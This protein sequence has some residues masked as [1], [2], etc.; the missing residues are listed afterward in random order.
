MP[1]RRALTGTGMG[2][3]D[4]EPRRREWHRGSNHESSTTRQQPPCNRAGVE[5]PPITT[6][7]VPVTGA[8]SRMKNN[9]TTFPSV[10]QDI[11]SPIPSE[12]PPATTPPSAPTTT[13]APNSAHPRDLPWDRRHRRTSRRS[14]SRSRCGWCSAVRR[15]R[16][17]LRRSGRL[18][19]QTFEADDHARSGC[20]DRDRGGG[21]SGGGR[22][23]VGGH[24]G[25]GRRTA[26]ATAASGG[27][28]QEDES[29]PLHP[30]N[31]TR[32]PRTGR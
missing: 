20:T 15:R 5:P 2:L 19:D 25:R 24:S 11:Q 22:R 3:R 8:T 10:P 27:K 7:T 32:E 16:R 29:E 14:R 30:R 9:R 26:V 4:R 1:G 28:C 21:R 31:P 12:D 23:R 13:V 6:Q 18:R 17:R